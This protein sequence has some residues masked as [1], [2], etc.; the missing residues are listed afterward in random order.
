[1]EKEEPFKSMSQD[2]RPVGP[3][4]QAKSKT[5]RGLGRRSGPKPVE[6]KVAPSVMD[7]ASTSNDEAKPLG[8]VVAAGL[9]ASNPTF[10]AT[11][12]TVTEHTSQ[13]ELTTAMLREH[14][15]QYVGEEA[16]GF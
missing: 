7:G 16:T 1:M 15:L 12:P 4:K 2:V 9:V 14:V 8:T 6:K 13:L 5:A 11:Q 3:P 10:I